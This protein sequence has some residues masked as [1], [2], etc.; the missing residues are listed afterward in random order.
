MIFLS[1]SQ[2]DL[3]VN[4]YMEFPIGTDPPGGGNRDDVLKPNK[5]LYVVK[6]ASANWFETL[7]AG[8]NSIEFQ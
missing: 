3:D 2:A 6:Q 5:Y 8:L 4:V 1:F 7:K